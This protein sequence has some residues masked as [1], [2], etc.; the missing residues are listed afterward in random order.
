MADMLFLLR[1]IRRKMLSKNQLLSYA[2]YGIGEIFLVVIGILI[3]V[4]IDDWNEQRKLLAQEDQYL[5]RLIAENEQDL[6]N[7]AGFKQD[8]EKAIAS[9]DQFCRV[10]KD[11]SSSDSLILLSIQEY[12]IYGSLVPNFSSSRSTFDDLSSTGNLKVITNPTLRDQVVQHYAN[13]Q[14]IQERMQINADWALSLDTQFYSELDGMK[15]VPWTAHLFPSQTEA[16]LAKDLR[17]HRL[18]YINNASAGYWVDRD[19][20][21]LID[22]LTNQTRQLITAMKNEIGIES[23][24]LPDPVAAGWAGEMVCEV[25]QE[26]AGVRVLRCTFP[27][28]VGHEPHFHAPHV[29]YTVVGGRFQIKDSTGV[30]ELNVPT[31]Y[32]YANEN[33]IRHEVLNIGTT[34]AQFLIIEPN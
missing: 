22:E 24:T 23:E 31:G 25:L 10:L 32:A 14:K 29:G 11:A 15:F 20:I 34:T 1:N 30:R 16:E 8:T 26:I 7:F 4:Q 18:D 33:I 2:L 5:E 27:P 21:E 9:I 19:A 6:I 12:M 28:G 3:A 17:K 13:I